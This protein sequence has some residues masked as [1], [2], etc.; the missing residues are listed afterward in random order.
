M[1]EELKLKETTK[2]K[3]MTQTAQFMFSE[4]WEQY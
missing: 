3:T 1:Y 4:S 2:W